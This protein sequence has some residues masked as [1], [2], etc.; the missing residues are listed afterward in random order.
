MNLFKTICHFYI[1]QLG[2]GGGWYVEADT[3]WRHVVNW[4][5]VVV[6]LVTVR[7]NAAL[8]CV[9]K[10][11][12]RRKPMENRAVRS[13]KSWG[14]ECMWQNFEWHRCH[15]TKDKTYSYQ[16]ATNLYDTSYIPESRGSQW[17][18]MVELDDFRSDLAES[19][20]LY[21]NAMLQCWPVEYCR[22][23]ASAVLGSA[24][25]QIFNQNY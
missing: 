15:Q 13:E 20:L 2:G 19:S 3:C 11:H 6:G 24:P 7:L 21:L 14:L 10:S 8:A 9:F 25:R 1:P 18:W 5:V 22:C 4:Q 16:A 12:C 23:K 17:E